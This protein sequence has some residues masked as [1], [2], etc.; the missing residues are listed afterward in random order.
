MDAL[1]N[2][3][4]LKIIDF[5]HLDDVDPSEFKPEEPLITEGLG[6]DSIDLLELV[7]LLEKDYG[8]KIT[9]REDAQKAFQSLVTLAAYI[10]EHQPIGYEG[11]Q[12]SG[13]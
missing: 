11:R 7:V 13:S 2:E 1:I 8:I 3:L 10:R 5:L 12:A 6:L 4:K 9:T